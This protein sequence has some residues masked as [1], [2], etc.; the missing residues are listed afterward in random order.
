EALELNRGLCGHAVFSGGQ[1]RQ[2]T[3]QLEPFELAVMFDEGAQAVGRKSE[4]PHAGVN[5]QMKFDGLREAARA[6]GVSVEARGGRNRRR[7]TVLDEVGGIAHVE[8]AEEQ[9]RLLN[10]GAP[11]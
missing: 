10:S 9:N 6:L 7:Q 2:K 8:P 5:L 11:Q 3:R 4:A 1:V